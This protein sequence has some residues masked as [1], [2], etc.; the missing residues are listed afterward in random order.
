[1]FG[2]VTGVA[3]DSVAAATRPPPSAYGE[4]QSVVTVFSHSEPVV[5]IQ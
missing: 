2:G 1:M 4:R 3:V 5:L